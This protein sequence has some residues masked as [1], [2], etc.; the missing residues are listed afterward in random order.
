MRTLL[1]LSFSLFICLPSLN[2]QTKAE[3]KALKEEAD[4]KGYENIQSLIDSNSYEFEA[5]WATTQGGKRI[6][7][8]GNS[9]FLKVKD[10]KANASLPYFGVAQSISYGGDG[11]IK[12][13]SDLKD[14]NVERVDKKKK[15]IIKG[16]TLNSREN[17]E[18]V[19]TVFQ[20]G[21][22]SLF[23]SSLSRNGISYD[24]KVKPISVKE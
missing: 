16:K 21:N 2:A 15:L 8:I 23:V 4:L 24:G 13:E 6:N 14:Y 18:I 20:N 9:G 3:K 11:G 1:I 7:L 12:F 17:F 19:L 5:E 22:A 10:L